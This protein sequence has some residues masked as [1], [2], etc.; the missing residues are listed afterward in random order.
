MFIG[1]FLRRSVLGHAVVALGIALNTVGV[2][3]FVWF[4]TAT[5]PEILPWYI[6]LVT[7]TLAIGGYLTWREERV[8]TGELESL[9]SVSVTVGSYS[10]NAPDPGAN[11]CSI[12]VH[13]LWSIWF[14]RD[15]A[16]DQV[17]VN[18]VEHYIWPR[19]KFWATRSTPVRSIP[20][21]GFESTEYREQLRLGM[22][23]P[24]RDEGIFE[25]VG[26]RPAD[27]VGWG[28]VF[29]LKTG[30]PRREYRIPLA[31][32]WDQVRNRRDHAPL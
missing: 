22:N 16:T 15:V 20:R 7:L 24:F 26:D 17:G 23:Q 31:V 30:V 11:K 3:I 5:I 9:I 32:D 10:L 25:H 2:F 13:V 8:K 12:K 6:A 1:E 19:W 18:L 21:Q 4:S 14:E 27:N 29:V 28:L